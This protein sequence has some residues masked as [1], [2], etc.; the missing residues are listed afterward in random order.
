MS[1]SLEMESG[2]E[3]AKYIQVECMRITHAIS[4]FLMQPNYINGEELYAGANNVCMF[5]MFTHS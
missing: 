4:L 1:G 5:E 3:I 2:K